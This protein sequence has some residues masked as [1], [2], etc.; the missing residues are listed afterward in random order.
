MAALG[1]GKGNFGANCGEHRAWGLRGPRARRRAVVPM[2]ATVKAWNGK[3]SRPLA[4]IFHEGNGNCGGQCSSKVACE[5]ERHSRCYGSRLRAP[6]RAD[7]AAAKR[8]GGER[9]TTG[10]RR[11]RRHPLKGNPRRSVRQRLHEI[12]GP[13]GR[14]PARQLRVR[15]ASRGSGPILGGEQGLGIRGW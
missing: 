11:N 1:P 14:A 12:S 4:R 6:I 9:D 10:L 5:A 8:F 3:A 13:G 2:D 7:R 15:Y